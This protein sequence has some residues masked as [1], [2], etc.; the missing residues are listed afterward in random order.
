MVEI[1]LKIL[2]NIE[3]SKI[4]ITT[5][6]NSAANHIVQRLIKYD[7]VNTDNL[8]RLIGFNYGRTFDDIEIKDY[9]ST[10]DN[11]LPN[12][13]SHY[14]DRLKAVKRFKIV[15][16]T[17]TTIAK[18]LDSRDLYNHFTHAIVDE[19]GQSSELGVLI[20]MALVG[21]NGQTVMAGDPMQMPPIAIDIHAKERGLC[22]S[23][24]SRLLDC[25]SHIETAVRIS[26]VING[27]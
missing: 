26:H 7:Q 10:I 16:G 12:S 2:T 11:L 21:I 1:I 23:M 18:L 19:A 17:S 4:L 25:Y 20:S 6:S 14:F 9:A 3:N 24:L 27:F 5:H 22:I 13:A 15:V 8:L